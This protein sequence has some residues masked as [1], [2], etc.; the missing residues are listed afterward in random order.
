M[1]GFYFPPYF[2]GIG[3]WT[4]QVPDPEDYSTPALSIEYIDG[5]SVWFRPSFFNP[6]TQRGRPQIILERRD[7]DFFNSQQFGCFLAS[8]YTKALPSL[9]EKKLP[10]QAL[11]GKYSYKTHTLD[12]FPLGVTYQKLDKVRSFSQVTLSK[13]RGSRTY[14]TVKSWGYDAKSCK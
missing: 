2:D 11:L 7:P 12:K 6:M 4:Y 1:P 5:T 9:I 3:G 10:T 8:L 13:M 14:T